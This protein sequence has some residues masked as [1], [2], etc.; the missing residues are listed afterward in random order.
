M[1]SVIIPTCDRPAEFLRAAIGSALAQ[2]L[3]PHEVIVVDNGTI[4]ADPAAIPA[5]VTLHRLPPR[6]GPSRARNFGA[7]MASGTHLA[8]LDDDDWWD[9]DFL[10]E[11]WAVLQA[12]GARCVYGRKD[13]FRDGR[14]AR[15]KCPS[16][17]TLT[18]PVLLR[19]N[20]GT[21][22]INLLIEKAL[23]WRIGG[24]DE[25]LIVGEDISLP[26]EVLRTGERIA[27]APAAA[28][29]VRQHD[30]GRLTGRFMVRSRRVWKYR[31]LLGWRETAQK[32]L[33]NL[34]RSARG[35]IRS[36]FDGRRA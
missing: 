15:Y 6:V 32:L 16:P 22:G 5:G 33:R 2:S 7:A 34:Y 24:F 9:K 25:W 14:I 26:L 1:I 27:V 8:F 4:D 28:A 29:I 35:A 19:R 11:A 36:P 10:R 23:F 13:V 31:R 20:P 18:I 3:P 12:E 21:G 30:G 17:E